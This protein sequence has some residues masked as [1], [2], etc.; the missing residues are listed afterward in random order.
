MDR[1]TPEFKAVEEERAF[2]AEGREFECTG[3]RRSRDMS[4]GLKTPERSLRLQLPGALLEEL[5]VQTHL[6]DIPVQSLLKNYLVERIEREMSKE[7][8]GES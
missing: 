7:R 6:M 1:D 5:R 4:G 8:A 3:S 2:W